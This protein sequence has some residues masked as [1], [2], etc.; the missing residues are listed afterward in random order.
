MET[1]NITLSEKQLQ[2]YRDALEFY[3][4]FLSGQIEESS[5]PPVLRCSEY[6]KDELRESLKKVKSIIFPELL[7]N[8]Y[9]GI[10]WNG[11]PL[12]E[13]RQVAYEMYREVYVYHTR[14]SGVDYS[15]YNSPTLKY[16]NEPLAEVKVNP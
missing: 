9:Y 15:C 10:G 7:E 3:S 6:N 5:L 16:S 8:Q 4:R 1:Y 11:K 2:V 12:S 14:L 13:Q